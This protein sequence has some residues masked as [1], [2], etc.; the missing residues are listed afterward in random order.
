MRSLLAHFCRGHFVHHA[1]MVRCV[2]TP[3]LG[4]ERERMEEAQDNPAEQ[5]TV[6]I[7]LRLC[8]RVSGVVGSYKK[9]AHA[10]AGGMRSGLVPIRVRPLERDLSV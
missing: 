4:R 1:R 2:G 3:A 10:L 8:L 9:L 6:F 5:Q 7:L